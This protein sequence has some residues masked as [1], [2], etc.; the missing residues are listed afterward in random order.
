MNKPI[1]L[2]LLSAQFQQM[3]IANGGSGNETLGRGQMQTPQS[4]SNEQQQA[5]Q[6]AAQQSA[7]AAQ[8]QQAFLYTQ[9]Y[10]GMP[11]YMH[12]Q[13]AA[14]TAATAPYPPL[15]VYSVYTKFNKKIFI[16]LQAY[17]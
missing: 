13:A 10:F 3:G 5:S 17:S 9:P 14:Q 2:D 8:Q 4:S 11:Y 15:F 6:V 16:L 1:Q 12:P 7:T